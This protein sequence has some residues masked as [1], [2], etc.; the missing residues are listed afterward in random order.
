MPEFLPCLHWLGRF[1]PM[2][3]ALAAC[4]A[5]DFRDGLSQARAVNLVSVRS[6][7]S[8]AVRR[9]PMIRRVALV[10][11]LARCADSLGADTNG[12]GYGPAISV[13]RPVSP[14]TA[15]KP[16][17]LMDQTREEALKKSRGCLQCHQ[18]IEEMHASPNVVLGC[19]DCHGGNATPDLLDLRKAHVL[20]RH[21][22]FWNSA[23][24]PNDSSVLLNHESIDFIRFVNPADLRVA[25]INCG[26][27]HAQAVANVGNSMMRHGA[28]LWGAA[29]YNNGSVPHKNYRYGQAYGA[30]GASCCCPRWR[31]LEHGRSRS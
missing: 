23:A 11:A 2:A 24:N 3:E 25:S 6:F 4:V 7:T 10:L 18:G 13:A 26:F 22:E 15:P 27:C 1:Q 29:L 20:P 19:V 14:V 31:R 28:M 17:N 9:A 12:A 8:M 16:H 30:D 5:V 21:P